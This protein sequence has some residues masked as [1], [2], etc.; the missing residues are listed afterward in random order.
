MRYFMHHLAEELPRHRRAALVAPAMADPGWRAAACRHTAS[1]A[2]LAARVGMVESVG[3]ALAHAYERGTA[4][5]FPPVSRVRMCR[6]RFVWSPPLGTPSCGPAGRAGRQPPRSSC[7]RRDRLDPSM[8]D[9]LVE[10]GERWLAESSD[11]PCRRARRRA[12]ATA[13]DRTERSRRSARSG[14]RLHRPQ[15]AVSRRASTGV[16]RSQRPLPAPGAADA[17]AA[18]I[19]RARCG[20]MS[21]GSHPQRSGTPQASA[22]SNGTGPATSLPE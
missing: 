20:T 2:R 18:T 21:G 1:G 15:V 7:H 17:E 9:A 3:V 5:G 14:G 10:S 16:A 13:D 12:G 11:D 8:V 4:K 6:W 22:R 19:G